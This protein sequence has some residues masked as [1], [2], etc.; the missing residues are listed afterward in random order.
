LLFLHLQ[1]TFIFLSL[2]IH[3]KYFLIS[4]NVF[5]ESL[6]LFHNSHIQIERLQMQDCK[7]L[8][9]SSETEMYVCHGQKMEKY[10]NAKPFQLKPC[11]LQ[12]FSLRFYCPTGLNLLSLIRFSINNFNSDK[13]IPLVSKLI[14]SLISFIIFT[15]LAFFSFFNRFHNL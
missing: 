15:A 5:Y 12:L 9:V 14:L 2:K 13:V 4:K 8:F 1:F 10:E 7:L 11:S 3:H 6:F